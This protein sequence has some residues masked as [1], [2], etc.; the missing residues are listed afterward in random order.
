M[1]GG[2]QLDLSQNPFAQVRPMQCPSTATDDVFHV[3]RIYITPDTALDRL[4]TPPPTTALPT[5]V[6]L[7][8]ELY[9][10]TCIG[11]PG[12]PLE[13]DVHQMGM[14][15]ASRS[16]VGHIEELLDFVG[17]ETELYLPGTR[18]SVGGSV[19]EVDGDAIEE[20]IRGGASQTR[21]VSSPTPSMASSCSSDSR[22][23]LGENFVHLQDVFRRPAVM[24]ESPELLLSYF[25]KNTC[26]IMSIKDGPTENPWRTLIWPLARDSQALYHAISSMTAFHMSR[27]R[28]QLRVE[29]MEHMRRSIRFLAQG[30]SHGNIR[31]DAALGTT[32]VLAFSEAFDTHIST[33]I[34]HLR[35]ARVLINQALARISPL[36]VNSEG[37]QR[38]QFL[39]N[40]WVYL[41]VL[42]GLTSDAEE[43]SNNMNPKMSYAPLISSFSIDPL[44]GCAA[45][46]FPLIGQAARLVQRVRKLEKNSVGIIAAAMDL[47]LLLE[48][49]QVQ[50]YYEPIEDP[51]SDVVHCITTAEAYRWATLLYLHQ[52]VPEL[53]SPDAHELADKVMRLIASIP[54]GSRC[55]IV[56]IY[57]L[58]AAGCEAVGDEERIWV[59]DRWEGMMN[60]M[61][62]G[63]IDKAWQVVKEV[64][65]RRDAFQARH[66]AI[67]PSPTLSP[68][69]SP[70]SKYASPTTTPMTDAMVAWDAAFE[71]DNRRPEPQRAKRCSTDD[72]LREHRKGEWDY[73]VS[74]RGS[75]HW[76][77]VMKHWGWEVLLG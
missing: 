75:L 70:R 62:I 47:K 46:L 23:S 25:D 7:L 26:G 39:Y 33:G 74:I 44:L 13:A 51:S 59:R 71:P 10:D 40:V 18:Y 43:D 72:I 42:A 35:G 50:E 53:P 12:A 20:M 34:E 32:L 77:G 30:L 8:E 37:F 36:S 58:L 41:D 52:A 48:S 24:V 45:T 14:E 22:S 27:Q 57:P 38:L 56:H 4:P 5:N 9:G 65:Y 67:T 15:I 29:G 19:N 61:W 21:L 55:C 16:P 31:E 28:P 2:G 60:R 68:S 64:W 6:D 49:W 63:N 11:A 66:A 3:D 54:P 73:E 17:N 76:L 69:S 1:G